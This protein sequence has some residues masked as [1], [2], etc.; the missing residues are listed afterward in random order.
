MDKL[1]VDGGKSASPK[2]ISI[3]KPMINPGVLDEIRGILESG[4][5]RQ[6][7][8][9][10]EFEALFAEKVGARYAY[11]VN[12]GTA[13]LHAAY[14]STLR[15]GDE[16][17]VPAFTFLATASM[18]HYSMARPVFA[19]VDPETFLIDPEDVK[20]KITPRTR[21]VVP[22]HL[23]GNAAD[24]HALQD[25]CSDHGLTLIHDSAQAHGTRYDGV[26]VGS[27]GDLGCYSFY[28]SKTL[29]TG[30]GGMVTTNDEALHRRGTLIRAH[31]D[32][33]R[34][35]HVLMGFNYRLT[36]IA[37]VLGIDQMRQFDG[38]LKRRKECGKYLKK[39]IGRIEGLTPQKATPKADHSY[40]YFSLTM[41]PEKFRCTRDQFLAALSAENIE[42]AVHYPAP[43][44]QQPVVKE[45]LD[46]RPCPA[47]EELSTRI[48]S[49]PMHPALSDDDLGLIVSAV[50]KVA[51]HYLK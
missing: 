28:P 26:D 11:A 3:A 48:F 12:N 24:I 51:S 25:L 40:S 21:A 27:Y 31:G 30:E 4:Q 35:H 38:F 49:L 29:T 50:E 18:V 8:K 6:G 37:A 17:I 45:M 9:V 19:D 47:S 1:A 33:G 41:D 13:A 10:R 44:T 14:L 46:P 34:Y 15:P 36:E 7:R 23:F 42:C 39:R 16:A 5:L 43:L 32:D 2:K 22:V 20:E